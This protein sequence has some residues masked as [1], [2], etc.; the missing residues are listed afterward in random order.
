MKYFLIILFFLGFSCKK[1]P[2]NQKLNSNDNSIIIKESK[3][4][5]KTDTITDLKEKK[6]E[7]IYVGVLKKIYDEEDYF[8]PLYFKLSVPESL[9]SEFHTSKSNYIGKLISKTDDHE[10]Y[11]I[12][13]S[14]AKKYFNTN[15]LDTIMVFNKSQKIIDT[16]YR[17]NYEYFSDQIESQVM[18]TYGKTNKVNQ[19]KDY[20]SISQTD[21][22]LRK[23]LEFEK[24]SIYLKNTLIKNSFNP[25]NIYSHYKM[26]EN[27]DTISFMSFG[28]YNNET[29]KECFYLLK[30]KKPIDSIIN[31][32]SISKMIAVPIFLESENLY[33]SYEFIPDTGSFWTSLIGIDMKNNKLT[34]YRGNRLYKK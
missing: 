16:L 3:T 15:G 19:N 9:Y 7:S 2:K 5:Q 33:V 32:Y 30:N 22:V 24:D 4:N 29:Q 18:V 21:I 28:I 27:N 12:E 17:K 6:D 10:R 1:E 20:L 11:E 14:I 25:S 8:L 26:T 34:N 31:E 23:K 13:A